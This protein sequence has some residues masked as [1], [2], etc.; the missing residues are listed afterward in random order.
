M[1]P[2]EHAYALVR[3]F[4][5]Y[6]A[7]RDDSV[8]REHLRIATEWLRLIDSDDSSA[9]DIEALQASLETLAS[10]GSATIDLKLGVRAW[11][12]RARRRAIMRRKMAG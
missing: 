5:G 1:T 3:C 8:N 12:P 11:A 7:K 10:A 2:R 9:T 4:T 6:A